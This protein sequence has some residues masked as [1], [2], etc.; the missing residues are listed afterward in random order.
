VSHIQNFEDAPSSPL[1]NTASAA[2]DVA[3]LEG[4][5]GASPKFWICDTTLHH[6]VIDSLGLY[7][8]IHIVCEFHVLVWYGVALT[9]F[10]KYICC[11]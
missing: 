2:G 6:I 8:M 3:S 1:R 11:G 9:S 10:V 4:D 5:E 7:L